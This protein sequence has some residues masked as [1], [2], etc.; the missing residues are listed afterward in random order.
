MKRKA[1]CSLIFAVSIALTSC[2]IGPEIV[3]YQTKPD[4]DFAATTA[5]AK[6]VLNALQ[7][8]SFPD[9]REYCGYIGLDPSGTLGATVATKGTH[10]GCLS[11]PPPVGWTLIASYHTHGGYSKKFAA[12]IPSREDLIA[13]FNEG[14]NGYVSTPEGRFWYVEGALKQA[15]LICG[16]GCLAQDPTHIPNPD[17]A[18]SYTLSELNKL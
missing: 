16:P 2:S 15:T 18:P 11:D 14:V 3:P 13:D 8:P 4:Y 17:I 12:E 1:I 10:Q 5:L 9:N 7:P 6:D